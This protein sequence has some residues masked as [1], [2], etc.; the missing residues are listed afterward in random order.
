MVAEWQ[1]ELILATNASM[2]FGEAVYWFHNLNKH[3][4]QTSYVLL[5][6]PATISDPNLMKPFH[7]LNKLQIFRCP[8]NP[9]LSYKALN[10]MIKEFEPK[11]VIFP[12][13]MNVVQS[14]EE[15]GIF[16]PS[17]NLIKFIPI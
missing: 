15:T 2:R 3:L 7:G 17:P 4:P 9:G 13:D 10:Q 16:N 11:T 6:D 1:N 12:K 14:A 5:T 8:L